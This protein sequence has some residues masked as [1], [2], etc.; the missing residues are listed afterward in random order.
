MAASMMLLQLLL[1]LLLLVLQLKQRLISDEH[2]S[3][4]ARRPVRAAAYRAINTA[5]DR[6]N[7]PVLRV[8]DDVLNN[9][10]L[11]DCQMPRTNESI[12]AEHRDRMFPDDDLQMAVLIDDHLHPAFVCPLPPCRS[13]SARDRVHAVK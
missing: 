4:T 5:P 6:P 7:G 10:I 3:L 9:T 1:Q 8:S 12:A 13:S 11:V 2:F